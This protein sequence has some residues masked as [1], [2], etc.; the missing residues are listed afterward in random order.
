MY[1]SDPRFSFRVTLRT[2]FPVTSTIASSL[3]AAIVNYGAASNARKR[4][5]NVTNWEHFEISFFPALLVLFTYF[6]TNLFK[7]SFIGLV[8]FW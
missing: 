3:G 7:G 6:D 8:T 2:V 1:P 5:S 4:H